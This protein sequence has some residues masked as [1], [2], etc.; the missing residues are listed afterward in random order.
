MTR[1]I[2]HG[3]WQTRDNKKNRRDCNASFGLG[4]ISITFQ[5]ASICKNKMPTVCTSLD[6]EYCKGESTASFGNLQTVSRDLRRDHC[7]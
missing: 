4:H 7:E 1:R 3:Q 6:F 2:N 5:P